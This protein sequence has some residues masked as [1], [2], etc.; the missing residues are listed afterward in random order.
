M[1]QAFEHMQEPCLQRQWT[2]LSNQDIMTTY[3]ELMQN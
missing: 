1:I 3:K 2:D